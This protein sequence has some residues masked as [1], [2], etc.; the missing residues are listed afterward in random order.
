MH[1]EE[2]VSASHANRINT[3]KSLED[4]PGEEKF[5]TKLYP[6]FVGG[7]LQLTYEKVT[8]SLTDPKEVTA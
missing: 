8:F 5:V 6:P 7:H 1:L 4:F 3:T 2:K